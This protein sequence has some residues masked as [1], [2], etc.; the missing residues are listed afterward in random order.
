MTESNLFRKGSI[1]Y[2][3]STSQSINEGSQ[4]RKLKAG[5]ETK[6]WRNAAYSLTP[7]GLLSLLSYSSRDHQLALPTVSWALKHP[8]SITNMYHRFAHSPIRWKHFP[9]Q[10][11]FFP[12]LVSSWDKTRQYKSWTVFS[13]G[14]NMWITKQSWGDWDLRDDCTVGCRLDSIIKHI[15]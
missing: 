15:C 8:S 10:D 5:T 6:P 11:F 3:S 2:F 7:L 12:D 14:L 1:F 9:K 13:A 4:G